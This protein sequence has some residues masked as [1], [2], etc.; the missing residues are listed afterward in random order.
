MVQDRDRVVRYEERYNNWTLSFDNDFAETLYAGSSLT[1]QPTAVYCCSSCS[2]IM[3]A[4]LGTISKASLP[5]IGTSSKSCSICR[6]LYQAFKDCSDDDTGTFDIV[7][8]K[9]AVWRGLR[10]PRLLRLYSNP[11]HCERSFPI[12]LPILRE[13]NNSHR[14]ALIRAWL[15]W[16]DKS[17]NCNK[18]R[19]EPEK[20]VPTRLLFVGRP[21]D[22]GHNPDSVRLVHALE[23][24]EQKYVALSHCWGNLSLDEKKTYCTTQENIVQRQSGFK[25]SDLPKTFQ[26]AVQVTREIGVQYL[27]IDSLCIIQYGDNGDDWKVQCKKMESVFSGAYCV[28]AA[29]LAVDSNAGFLKRDVSTEYA[30]VQNKIGEQFY[31]STDIDDF[32]ADVGQAQLNNRAWVLQE[33]V[34]ARRTIHFSAN[35]MYWECGEGIYCENLTRLKSSFEKTY[36]TL[37]PEFPDRLLKSGPG[38][39]IRFLE[40][41][42]E[43]YSKR[44]L[45]VKTDRCVA[46]SGL[47]ARIAHALECEGRFGVFQKYLHR[48]LLWQAS[49]LGCEPI[50]YKDRR[51]P[52]W[53]WMANAGGVQFVAIPFGRVSWVNDLR[54]DKNSEY[55]LIADLGEFQNCK[56]NIK[57][58]QHVILDLNGNK[59]GWI[60]YDVGDVKNF[61]EERCVVVGRKRNNS[62]Y[63]I[64][65][66]EPTDADGE[67]KRVGVGS[68]ED[69]YVVR[70]RVGVR[71]V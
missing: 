55:A 33:A 43:N 11:V 28:V 2:T 70:K 36:F 5:K 38:R 27:W 25:I 54:F 40:F 65:V 32:D 58:N 39:T 17:H 15:D 19:D 9:T 29:T 31:I 57:G 61:N 6:V 10:G 30:Y 23:A 22:S 47:A 24:D 46:V 20:I 68:V 18:H 63:Y 62:D 49:G 69:N 56:R 7:R 3:E 16:C 51:V 52:S 66:V 50:A 71:I 42:F 21:R 64:L 37:D 44:G 45:T 53:S 48:N 60:H 26:D 12:G 14:A 8:R 67:Y 35:Q 59:K 13:S 41:L 34:L 4:K 1:V